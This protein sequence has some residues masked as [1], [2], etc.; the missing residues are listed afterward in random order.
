MHGNSGR[1][2]A[3]MMNDHDD[4]RSEMERRFGELRADMERGFGDIRVEVH[5]G[6]GALRVEMRD[7]N[8]DL[9]K[10]ALVFGATQTAAIAGVVAL[11]R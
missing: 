2:A 9:L 7:R 3:L 4:L 10:W 1:V 6:F 11:L 8:A 5:Q